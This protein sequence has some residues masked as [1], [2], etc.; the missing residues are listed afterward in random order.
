MPIC[1]ALGS[2]V[3]LDFVAK[4]RSLATDN[5]TP[6]YRIFSPCVSSPGLRSSSKLRNC[7]TSGGEFDEST[8]RVKSGV[9]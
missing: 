8:S 5:N 9:S 2:P 4:N 6:V 3:L 7:L 1:W